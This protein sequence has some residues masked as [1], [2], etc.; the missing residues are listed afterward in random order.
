MQVWVISEELELRV[1]GS[2]LRLLERCLSKQLS[3]LLSSVRL[4]ESQ[5][6]IEMSVTATRSNNAV[7]CV[8]RS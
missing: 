8:H 2:L 1:A 7:E 4:E 3:G 6:L 5:A